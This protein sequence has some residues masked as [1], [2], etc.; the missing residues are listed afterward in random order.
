M[1]DVPDLRAL[2]PRVRLVTSRTRVVAGVL[3]AGYLAA[4]YLV[5][6]VALGR[7]LD[8]D[9][10]LRLVLAFA[11]AA[12]VAVTLRPL[13]AWLG[14]RL[15]PS[16]EE[17]LRRLETRH[18]AW[19]EV[20][21]A[22]E[23]LAQLVTQA[24][25]ASST[26][27]TAQLGEGL[28]LTRRHPGTRPGAPVD[29]PAVRAGLADQVVVEPLRRGTELVGEIV[30]RL[31]ATRPLSPVERRL[32]TGAAGCATTILD[33]SRMDRTLS[34]MVADAE[35][36]HEELARSRSRV[37]AVAETERRRVERDIHDGAQQ[38]LVAL[39][40]NLRLLR[41]LLDRDAGR[42]WSKAPSVRDACVTAVE[43]LEQLSRGLYPT[44]LVQA[45]LSAALHDLAATCPVPVV[46]HVD[47]HRHWPPE[48][49]RAV[50]FS[51]AEAL[52]NA[53]KHAS[54]TQVTVVVSSDPEGLTFEVADDGQGFDPRRHPAGSGTLNIADRLEAAGGGVR[55]ETAPGR[56]TTVRGRLPVPIGA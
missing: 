14:R 46:V 9:S 10:G 56:G 16:P 15:P 3:L 18:V 43:V 21:A 30:I 1:A 34:A 49:E 36:R 55:I 39:A 28:S 12:V 26:T 6:V 51:C 29:V 17:R 37:L 50:Y 13:R 8:P 20:G 45:G 5:V 38:H 7:G 25:G 31:P 22:L 53:V 23:Q 11:A 19:E 4:V 47:P 27:I 54:A 24:V 52:Q 44:Q 41:L 48:V 2:R 35:Q 40:M 42:A 33:V 32:V